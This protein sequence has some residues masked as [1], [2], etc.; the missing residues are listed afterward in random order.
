M[1]SFYYI[2][3]GFI[4]GGD[5]SSHTIQVRNYCREVFPK[6]T[7]PQIANKIPGLVLSFLEIEISEYQEE[8]FLDGEDFY[9]LFLFE[10]WRYLVINLPLT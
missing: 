8:F 1:H 2:N 4:L 6:P 3:N 10:R 5:V 9:K 7:P